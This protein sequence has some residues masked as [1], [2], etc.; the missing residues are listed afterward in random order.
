MGA[1]NFGQLSRYNEEF[2]PEL[3]EMIKNSNGSIPEG[4]RVGMNR[5]SGTLFFQRKNDGK[6][7]GRLWH[8]SPEEMIK[9]SNDW[10]S[11]INS[12]FGLGINPARINLSGKIEW[13]NMYGILYKKGGNINYGKTKL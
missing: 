8:K 3:I 6:V 7:I 2:T 5:S 10:I 12:E 1:N 13:P 9:S 4:I 11:K